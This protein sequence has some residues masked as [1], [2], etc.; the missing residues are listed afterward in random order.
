MPFPLEADAILNFDDAEDSFG[1]ILGECRTSF[2]CSHSENLRSLLAIVYARFHSQHSFGINFAIRLHTPYNRLE[3]Q[4]S[5][6]RNERDANRD[7]ITGEP[8]SH[9]LGVGLGTAAGGAVAGAAA[10]AVTGPIGAAVGAVVGGVAGG[11][12]GKEVAERID[13]TRESAFWRENY[14]SRDYYDDNVTYD[15]IEPAYQYGWESRARYPDRTWDEVEPELQAEWGKSE[16]QL[17]WE[18][19]RR[20]SH[21][22]WDRIERLEDR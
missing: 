2:D 1:D 9:P 20:A 7:A 16:R 5:T 6:K 3:A 21:D 22:A 19:A 4:M 18:R 10:G 12:A 13:P 15:A 8:G 11:L 17:E 14:S